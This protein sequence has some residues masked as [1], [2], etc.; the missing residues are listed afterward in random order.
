V[1]GKELSENMKKVIEPAL[2]LP[3]IAVSTDFPFLTL[4]TI[5]FR[6]QGIFNS[7]L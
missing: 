7:W 1:L 5:K 4:L 6:S 2:A 3:S